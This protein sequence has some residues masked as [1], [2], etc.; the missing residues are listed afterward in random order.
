[1]AEKKTENVSNAISPCYSRG[2]SHKLAHH[3]RR[4]GPSLA[5]REVPPSRTRRQQE[6]LEMKKLGQG[7]NN[8][9]SAPRI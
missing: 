5:A 6:R 1:M 3:D 2:D 4:K 7:Y 8:R 9:I